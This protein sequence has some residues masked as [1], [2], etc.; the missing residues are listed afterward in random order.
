MRRLAPQAFRNKIRFT[1]HAQVSREE[2]GELET[3][4]TITKAW[5]IKLAWW[6]EIRYRPCCTF[7]KL[8]TNLL[9]S[10]WSYLVAPP[11]PPSFQRFD[12]RCSSNDSATV[13]RFV[14]SD[15]WI[16]WSCA[17]YKHGGERTNE[18]N[19]RLPFLLCRVSVSSGWK[20]G[21]YSSR[22]YL[23]FVHFLL[24]FE[25]LLVSQHVVS[26]SWTTWRI[27]FMGWSYS[28]SLRNNLKYRAIVRTRE[29]HL[30]KDSAR[31][32]FIYL[33]P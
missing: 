32:F 6:D 11:P 27:F 13:M 16:G 31:L 3:Y 24:R 23:P 17:E 22:N 28:K 5:A 18:L 19:G 21:F 15:G 33:V 9:V 8:N 2:W 10:P 20:E 12:E 1:W 25:D 29:A 4:F 7:T 26:I 14:Y 30:I